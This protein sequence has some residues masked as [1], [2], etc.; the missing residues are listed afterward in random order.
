MSERSELEEISIKGLGVIEEATLELSPGFTVLTGETGAGKT[1][2]LTAL[3]LVLGGRAD[4]SLVRVGR[5]RL[6]TSATFRVTT[7]IE[8]VAGEVGIESEDH[9]LI[10][11]R[12]LTAE[13]KS[14]ATAG[15]VPVPANV[16]A[17]LGEGLIEIHGQSASFSIAKTIRQREILDRFCGLEFVD[18]FARYK[19]S[20]EQ[21]Q[22]KKAKISALRRNAQGREK[23]VDALREFSAAFS[24]IKPQVN[25]VSSLAIEIS[26]LSSVESLRE[27]IGDAG[28]VLLDEES[29]VVDALAKIKRNLES[30]SDRDPLIA[31]I[32]ETITDSYFQLS[33]ASQSLSIYLGKLEADPL[34]LESALARKAELS[35]FLKRYASAG[36]ADE[37]I[38]E[39]IEKKASVEEAIADLTGGDERLAAMEVELE[40]LFT[41]LV[42]SSKVLSEIRARYSAEMSEKVTEE[43]HRLSMPHTQFLCTISSPGYEDEL[44]PNIFSLHG[45][46]EISMLLRSHT[47]GPLVPV[48]KGA[49]GGELSR[50]MLALEVVLA[51]SQPVG[52]YIFD[53]VDAGVGGK[54][55]IEVGRRLKELSAHAQVIVVTHLAQVAA[56]ADSHFVVLKNDDGAVSQSDVVQ[57]SGQARVEEIAR[58]L[59]GREDSHSA[60]E[61]ATELLAMRG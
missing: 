49:S 9:R 51:H 27:A 20:L 45:A 41:Q 13:G 5:S 17:Q 19:D 30:V 56:W 40:L 12:I 28:T 46:D 31:E 55:A 8:K 16:L 36:E 10:L 50:V 48:A 22:N 39:M 32:L 42:A 18:I 44:D 21:Y 47:D 34:R 29:G 52:T 57:V 1:M 3:T 53:E 33:E 37:Q 15:G 26:R 60:R 7:E 6:S 2:V 23:E 25:E 43:I 38:V 14:K 61:H 4:S 35:A 59:A 11:S 58:M 24:K 54:A